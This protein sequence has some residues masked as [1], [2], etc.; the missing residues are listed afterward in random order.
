MVVP[1]SF[2]MSGCS[3]SYK[4]TEKELIRA[5][6]NAQVHFGKIEDDSHIYCDV[7]STWQDDMVACRL[8]RPSKENAERIFCSYEGG[9]CSSE[10]NP[11]PSFSPY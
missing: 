5:Q 2:G 10:A 7:V 1:L 4:L 6:R 9:G 8:Q 3:G 11:K